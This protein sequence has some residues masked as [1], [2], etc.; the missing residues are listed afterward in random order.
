ESVR[1]LLA[2]HDLVDGWLPGRAVDDHRPDL[3]AALA[4]VGWSELP[5][6]GEDAL[7]F[8]GAAAVEMGRAVAPFIDVVS[9]LGGSPSVQGLAMY[10]A[11]LGVHLVSL[12]GTST[13]VAGPAQRMAAWETA[14]VG[15]LAGLA[16][17]SVS[18]AIDHARHRQVFGRTLAQIETVQQR[19]AD[20]ATV[21]DSLVLA[22]H[23]G[24]SGLAALA[25]ATGAVGGVMTHCHQVLG[26][27][28]F[29]IEFPMQRYSRRAKAIASF[30]NAWIDQRL[31]AEA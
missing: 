31:D 23:E 15:Y 25:H 30:A 26:A 12:A 7:P 13:A 10:G 21:S 4:G 20:A 8:I 11:S 1:R 27:I 22:A 6:A 17:S 24:A 28:G 2:G 16:D 14:T 19:L 18:R 9:V 29:T 5:A 3:S